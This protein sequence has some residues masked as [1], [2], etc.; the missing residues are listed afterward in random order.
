MG[1]LV[2]SMSLAC[3][4]QTLSPDSAARLISALDGF[5]REAHFRIETGVPFQSAFS[6][7]TQAEVERTPLN[8]FVVAR[9]WVRYEQRESVIGFGTKAS[10]PAMAL[11]PAG[12]AASSQWTRGRVASNQGTAWTVPIGRRELVGVTEVRPAPDGSTQ[13]EFDWKWAPDETGMAL[14][15]SVP[16]ASVFFDQAR[17]GRASCRRRNDEWRCDLAMWAMAADVGEL[18]S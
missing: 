6:C 10:C 7:Y 17:K 16:Q 18:P 4:E 14:R 1:V 5:K 9:G 8:Q 15:S 11:T 13:V 3:S 12:E 2:A